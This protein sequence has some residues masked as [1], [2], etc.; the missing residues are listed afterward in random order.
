MELDLSNLHNV[1]NDSFFDYLKDQ[2]RYLILYGGSGSGKS[3]FIVQK[4]LIRI[5][6]GIQTGVK[7]RF[8]CL[9]KTAPAVKKSI[10]KEFVDLLSEWSLTDLVNIN[11]TDLT[12]TFS[13]GSEIMCSGFDDPEKIKSIAGLTGIWL[14]EATEFNVDDFLQLDLRLRGYTPSYKQIC[15]S[16]N[17]ISKLS[18]IHREFFEETK[19]ESLTIMHS[20]YH[21]NKFLDQKYRNHLQ[22]LEDKNPSYYKIYTLGEWGSLE[23]IIYNKWSACNWQMVEDRFKDTCYGLDIGYNAPTALTLCGLRDEEYYVKELL[24]QTKLTHNGIVAKLGELIPLKHRRSRIIYCD[25]AEPEL[26]RELNLAGFKA[27]LSDKSVKNGI[28]HIKNVQLHIDDESTNL[29]KEIQSYSYR[30]DRQGNVFD[31]PVKFNDHLMDAMRYA[32]YS[33]W[34]RIRPKASILFA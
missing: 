9:R 10:F 16:F 15:I 5:L 34:G 7:H 29:L 2:N 19:Y 6:V 11:K 18:W 24:Y 4:L 12:F 17:P 31:E 33:R 14:E 32:I 26:I 30:Q 13:N 27:M 8:L 23:H 3:K 25:S 22:S 28:D 1:I 20:T 21:D